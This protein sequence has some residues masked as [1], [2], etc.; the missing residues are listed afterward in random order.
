MALPERVREFCREHELLA[1]L[2]RLRVGF[3]GGADS[4]ALLLIL[5][6]LGLDLEAVHLHHGL[7]GAGAD[8][9]AAWCERFC[10]GRRIPFVLRRLDVPAQRRPGES[11]EEAGRRLRLEY[12][13]ETTPA[14]AAVALAHHLDDC[15]ED[16]LLRL[17]RGA[18]SGGLT[19]MQP[20]SVVCGVRILRPLLQV[21]RVEIEEFLAI[22]DLTDWRR[23][24]TNADTALRRNAVRHQW[25]PLIRATVGHDDGLCRSLEALRADADCLSD[26]ATAAVGAVSRPAELRRLHPALLPRVL[27]LWL[28]RQTGQDWVVPRNTLLRLRRDLSRFDGTPRRITLGRGRLVQ[29]DASGLHLVPEPV[30]LRSREWAWQRTS[31]LD[32][33]EAG[34]GLRAEVVG[35][36]YAACA[37]RTPES[38]VFDA[39]ALAA[40][41][42]VRAWEPGDRLVPFGRSSPVKL[43]DLFT[44]AHVPRAERQQF[45]VILS[46]GTV[47]WVPGLR[48]AEFGRAERGRP[49][50]VLRWVA[51]DRDDAPRAST[52]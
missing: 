47:I 5:V 17:A 43:Q 29:L 12:W 35:D 37:S 20:A 52:P 26:L 44:D 24:P 40:E 7:R 19:A 25:L 4:T 38:E 27:R 50:V 21:R 23:D 15:L 6:E 31:G 10:Q 45:P 42:R 2:Q 33:P 18:N 39:A 36:G 34:A 32:L 1:D 11:L 51:A 14:V 41:L 16:L 48:R 28:S 30:R 49:A 13:R 3:S 9:D 8:A 46:A 22:R